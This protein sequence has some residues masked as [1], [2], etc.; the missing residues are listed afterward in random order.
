MPYSRCVHGGVNCVMT[1]IPFVV[2]EIRFQI[3]F[4]SGV[5]VFEGIVTFFNLDYL[6]HERSR[7]VVQFV[8]QFRVVALI[9]SGS[10]GFCQNAVESIVVFLRHLSGICSH[11]KLSSFG[12]CD[13]FVEFELICYACIG[14]FYEFHHR[15]R[16]AARTCLDVAA[17]AVDCVVVIIVGG[18]DICASV[19]EELQFETCGV[20]TCHHN[21]GTFF[22][23]FGYVFNVC[24]VLCA[25]VLERVSL[26][27]GIFCNV[28]DERVVEFRI[29][30]GVCAKS[31]EV[32]VLHGN[33]A[34]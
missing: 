10:F 34:G 1:K 24:Q 15:C 12:S 19:A 3:V 32:S 22:R 33:H 27:V 30:A 17:L 13:G 31:P 29:F 21:I 20:C 28:P 16:V 25:A 9:R 6:S 14:N 7:C 26:A 4:A 23:S 18:V 11:R 8:Y 2:L 5:A